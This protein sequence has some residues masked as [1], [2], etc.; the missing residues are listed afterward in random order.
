MRDEVKAENDE[1]IA[2]HILRSRTRGVPEA[3]ID[4]FVAM[5]PVEEDKEQVII[6]GVDGKEHLSQSFL[7]KYI[8]F[9][10][11]NFHPNIDQD[12][13][14]LILEYY[15]QERQSFGRD[16]LDEGSESNVVP[17]TARALEALIRLTEAHARMFLRENATA[18]DA[19][20]A[21]AVFKHW[22]EESGIEDDSEFSGT[23]VRER[24]TSAIVKNIIRDI[25]SEN[26]NRATITSIYN[27]ALGKKINETTVDKVIQQ[28]RERGILF[29]PSKDEYGFA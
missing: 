12:V 13:M 22:R 20:V 6:E 28:M 21:L 3:L 14:A 9:A 5:D 18:E 4:E 2:K 15:V 23:T 10:K 29:N 17:I 16:D 24:N 26:G 25:C 11:R 27:S 1:M 8:A 19:K 7:R